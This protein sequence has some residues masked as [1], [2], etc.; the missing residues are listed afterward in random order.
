M[1]RLVQ[2][3]LDGIFALLFSWGLSL[4]ISWFE[5]KECYVLTDQKSAR[6]LPCLSVQSDLLTSK[7][8]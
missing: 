2:V 4:L 7:D 3:S 6:W 1:E 5:Q 8:A